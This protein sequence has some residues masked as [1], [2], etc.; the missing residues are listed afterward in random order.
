MSSLSA[1][2][3]PRD[4]TREIDCPTCLGT[5][6]VCAISRRAEEYCP[7]C[8]GLCEELVSCEDCGGSGVAD[9]L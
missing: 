1:A 2:P 5:C 7:F 3:T 4:N 8:T 9:V 6:E